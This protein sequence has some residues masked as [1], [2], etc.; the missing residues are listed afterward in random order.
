MENEN[1]PQPL[2]AIM[3]QHRLSSAD[4]VRASKEQLSFK[5]V[6]KGRTGRRLTPNV[7]DKILNALL[8]AKPGLSLR[9][10]DL[11]HYE[12]A[13]PVVGLIQKAISDTAKK[14]ISYAEF[15]DRLTEAGIN[16][17]AVDVVAGH[18][19]FFAAAG[20]AHVENGASVGEP[21]PGRFDAILLKYAITDA[22][23]GRIDHPAFLK[24]IYAAGI[25]SYE[26]NT[27]RRR[28]AYKG[29][30]GETYREIIPPAGQKEVPEAS[31]APKKTK[32]PVVKVKKV[33]KAIKRGKVWKSGTIKRHRVKRRR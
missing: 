12:P 27:R 28:I 8:L 10:R 3:S 15:I 17:Y 33:R 6:H 32:K 23:K 13:A 16:R 4:L 24:R 2:D 26:T 14:L 1:I 9:R 18:I 21:S 22:Q 7:Q 20:Q 5:M 31:A 25:V 19:T 29:A 30:A 11:F